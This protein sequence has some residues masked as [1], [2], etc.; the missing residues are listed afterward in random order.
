MRKK[1]VSTVMLIFLTLLLFFTAKTSVETRSDGVYTDP[2][3]SFSGGSGRV[4]ITCESVTL[5]GG[6]ATARISFSSPN[7]SYVKA[8]G[9]KYAGEYTEK[10][11]SFEIPVELDKEVRILGCTTAMS[12]P[13]EVEYVITVSLD[14][15]GGGDL[16]N[17]RETAGRG[18]A[19]AVETDSDPISSP[20]IEG[21]SPAGRMPLKYA[22]CF[23]VYYYDSETEPESRYSL[24]SV[25]DG[26][27]YL[28]LPEGGKAPE[29]L[30][31]NI[32][33]IAS[34]DNIYLAATSAM[35]LFKALKSIDNISFSGTEEKGWFIEEARDAM[36]DGRIVYAGKYSAPD[37]EKLLTKGADLAIES[38]MILH[39]PEVRESLKR[40][41]IPVFTDYSAYEKKAFGRMEWI[42][43]YGAVLGK[44][45][46]AREYYNAELQKY[47]DGISFENTGKRV[48]YFYL[49]NA[50][51]AV[52]RKSDDYLAD[53]IRAG[54]GIYA[55][56][57]IEAD[58]GD[59]QTAA[60]SLETLY[61]YAKNADFIIYDST[62]DPSVQ[63]VRDLTDRYA[64]FTDFT[65]V[66]EGK[67]YRTDGRMYQS[68]D[69]ICEFALDINRMVADENGEG[70]FLSK[71]PETSS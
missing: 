10:T 57:G 50:G 53:L 27:S 16:Q 38:T 6:R 49:N 20:D 54:G 55:F 24:I 1:A 29:G 45:T 31:G 28:V 11:S 13:H 26:N 33:V 67:V 34:S 42:K 17:T 32:Q 46:E 71:L 61:D 25:I 64:L 9:E 59:S 5:S 21:L 35:S 62:I 7:Y 4:K 19:G 63:S 43:A 15:S 14:D 44:E 65:A 69:R 37:Y 60:V 70:T 18:G 58:F 51:L 66:K 22:E 39:S 30:G 47:E 68:T 52:I 3:F 56:D 23:E 41:G 2:S 8:G 12:T 36:R 48:A 40:L